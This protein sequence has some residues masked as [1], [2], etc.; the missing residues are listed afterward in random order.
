MHTVLVYAILLLPAKSK[1][2]SIFSY[3]ATFT[4]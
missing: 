2:K 3:N 1:D 4:V